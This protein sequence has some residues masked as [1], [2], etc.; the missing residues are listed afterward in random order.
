MLYVRRHGLLKVDEVDLATTLRDLGGARELLVVLLVAAAGGVAA[1]RRQAAVLA[2]AALHGTARGGGPPTTS[3]SSIVR[4]PTSTSRCTRSSAAAWARDPLRAGGRR[5]RVIYLC[6]HNTL[7]ATTTRKNCGPGNDDDAGLLVEFGARIA[8]P[9]PDAPPRPAQGR[10]RRLRRLGDAAV[11][12]GGTRG[13]ARRLRRLRAVRRVRTAHAGGSGP[14]AAEDGV[15]VRDGPGKLAWT[16]GVQ[17]G[18]GGSGSG[19]REGRARTSTVAT[20]AQK[21]RLGA[22]GLGA[23]GSQPA[24]PECFQPGAAMEAAGAPSSGA[25]RKSSGPPGRSK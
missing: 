24:A 19:R 4:T 2:L 6:G 23:A 8:P 15:R 14:L 25:L 5:V 12:S 21:R 3:R 1:V 7:Y 16:P 9:A 11:R 10:G 13:V 18:A 17:G 20:A 22:Q